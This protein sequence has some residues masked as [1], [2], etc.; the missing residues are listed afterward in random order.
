MKQPSII[1]TYLTT[2]S[3]F[4][5]FAIVLLL[6][7]LNSAIAG[8]KTWT[9]ATNTDFGTASNWSP[10]TAPTTNDNIVIPVK[11]NMPI[12]N[13]GTYKIH[14]LIVQSGAS[15][16][17]NGG[18]LSVIGG[19]VQLTGTLNLTGGNFYTDHDFKMLTES[20]LNQSGSSSLRLAKDAVTNPNSKLTIA[21]GAT[22]NQGGGT[23][24]VKDYIS[25]PGTFN[26]TGSTALFRI[27]RDWRPGAGSKFISTSGTVEFAGSAG[28]G[29]FASGTR[30]FSNV[31]VNAGVDPKFDQVK[32]STV[33]ISG[34]FTNYNTSLNNGTSVTFTFNGTTPQ[35]IYSAVSNSSNPTFGN[36][37]I[38]NYGSNV[39]LT[40]NANVSGNILVK[41]GT[42]DLSTYTSNKVSGTGTLVVSAGATMRLAGSTGGQGN[43]SNFPA[44]QI[45]TLSAASTVEY[46]GSGQTIYS[47]PAYGNLTLSAAGTKTSTAALTVAGNFTL[48]TATFVSGSFTHNVGGNWSMTSGA[49]TNTGSII[50]FNGTGSQSIGSTGAFN[51]L[52]LNK[53]SGYTAMTTDVTANTLN[54]TK[55]V[56]ATGTNKMII[57]SG[58]IVT[59]ASQSTG[60][61][62]GT[63]Q[64]YIASISGGTFEIGGPLFYTP[65]SGTFG[66][67]GSFTAGSLIAKVAAS[68]QPNV[69]T[70][71]I[72]SKNIS[73]YWTLSKPATGAIAYNTSVLTFKWNVADNYSSLNASALKVVKYHSLAWSYPTIS[74]TPTTTSITASGIT[75]VGD[76]GVGETSACTISSGF[77]YSSNTLCTNSGNAAVVILNCSAIAGTFTAS[78]AGLSINSSTGTINLGASIP[79]IYTVINSVT[80]VCT[81][82]S[83]NT[84]EVVAAPS[85]LISYGS[86]SFCQSAGTINV[87][88]TGT[89][90]GTFTSSYGLII[91]PLTGQIDLTNS[92]PGT[93]TVTYAVTG[94]AGC[95]SFSTNTVVT[96]TPA[97]YA[98]INYPQT[99]Y[100]LN[101]GIA[102]VDFEGTTGGTF[103]STT[104]LNINSSTGAINLT[105]STPGTY[106][107]TYAGAASGSCTAFSDTVSIV[108]TSGAPASFSY[109]SSPYCPTGIATATFT[110]TTGGIFSST[111]ELA[112][113]ESTGDI[114]LDA[115]TSG[116]YIVTYSLGGCTTTAS[117]TIA[118]RAAISYAASTYCSGNSIAPATLTG[119]SGGSYTASAGLSINATTGAINPSASTVGGPYTITYAVPATGTCPTY[120]ITTDVTIVA[121]PSA[122]ISYSGSPFCNTAGTTAA[123]TVTGTAGGTFSST[124]GLA[125]NA[126]TGLVDLGA[127]T[128][129]TYTVTYTIAASAPCNQY[130]TTTSI[131]VITSGTWTGAIS[132]Q[133]NNTANWQCGVIPT[134][135]TNVIIPA[136]LFNYPV[137]TLLSPEIK[138]LTLQSGSLVTVTNGTLKINGD[139]TNNGGRITATNGKV[140]FNGSAAQNIPANL[141][142]FNVVKDL[143][144]TNPTSVTLAGA[145]RVTNTVDF[146]NVNNST[147]NSNG[148]LT[149]VST[150]SN[151]ANV[152]DLTNGGVNSGNQITG[153]V[154]V[155]RFVQGKR[156]YRFLTAPVNSTTSIKA[157]WMENT[158]NPNTGV[159]NN[160]VPGYGTH[161]TGN[162][163]NANGFDASGTNN[164]S[165]FSFNGA[166]QTWVAA[167]NTSGLF[168]AGNAVRMVV[169]GS[170]SVDLNSNSAAPSATTLRATGTLVTGPVVFAASG[171]TAGV[172]ALSSVPGAYNFIANPY[173][174]SVDWVSVA[175]ASTDVAPTL[176][177]FDPTITGSNGRGGYAYF[178]AILRVKNILNSLVT[179]DIQ[180]GQAFFVQTTGRNPT[181]TF[182]E[183]NKSTGFLPI[184]RSAAENPNLRFELLLPEQV[185]TGN[186]SDGAAVYFSDEYSTTIGDEDSYKFTNQ[187]ENLAIMRNGVALSL[188]GRKPVSGT[189]SVSLKIWQLTAS[190]YTLKIDVVNF[191]SNVEVYLEDRFLKETTLLQAGQNLIPFSVT[192]NTASA[193]SDRFKVVFETLATLPV[194]IT[195]VKAYSK[196]KGVQVD[197][198]AESE[199]NMDL[200]EIERAADAQH[201]ETVG[202]AK[203]RNNPG[204]AAAYNFFDVKPLAGDNYYRIKSLEKSGEIK[205]SEVVRVHIANEK[206]G[207][208]VVNNPVQGNSVKLLLSNIAEGNYMVKLINA[209]GEKVYENKISHSGGIVYKQLELNNRLTPGVYQLQ[210]SNGVLNKTISVL[211]Q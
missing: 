37:V 67:N 35:T 22:V 144:I 110:G 201:F 160:P 103:S 113:D 54:F 128:P 138:S 123:V 171:G 109:T 163:G 39:L 192:P 5:S 211:I 200:Y 57:P 47:T 17:Q 33:P 181:L 84:I 6:L 131:T 133:W 191:E 158:N 87:T 167:S 154:T 23:I 43:N 204:I 165:L 93:Y 152:S 146:G 114:D 162:G 66:N 50:N 82:S 71:T 99:A 108:I 168:K 145:V 190:K 161:I 26:Q 2:V 24:F 195:G 196:N 58:G 55:G 193:A 206:T 15:F 106:L 86:S 202:S 81:S 186:A 12:M 151:T 7:S 159:N 175:A 76:F 118:S 72:N 107:I 20:I 170:R 11:A 44:K 14:A 148:F 149:L 18:T 150:S 56:I 139:I 130:Q 77:S 74:G 19:S 156:A 40:S 27:L 205:L 126:T 78:P 30:Q 197:W 104:G 69:C 48:S 147:L 73:R 25:S 174:S 31:I 10:S 88:L 3:N 41:S 169:R 62:N 119:A 52:T 179:K 121:A 166:N 164:P 203:A 207:I 16:T 90:G 143:V 8:T 38:N 28:S 199:S 68:Q 198:V 188:E 155:E 101:G 184:F 85:T 140:E 137:V 178:N 65:V 209:L 32:N 97:N 91:D 1:K 187:D 80:S 116:T 132:T 100:C 96:V 83:P 194:R 177:I 95:A 210:V 134:S 185:S 120:T 182:N 105:S 21:T 136:G 45:A 122:T 46:Y 9:G 157:N 53:A 70:S 79:G 98:I 61:V 176:Y 124:T 4:V 49:F 208:S 34:N 189:D 64:K 60:W 51:G 29:D 111:P 94:N 89:T 75:T 173:A 172:T 153:D 125:I 127:S 117:V 42:F 142:S 183:T 112:I 102:A 92:N 180:S 13:A 141:F 129:G 59:G 135:T 63:M 36:L 115:S